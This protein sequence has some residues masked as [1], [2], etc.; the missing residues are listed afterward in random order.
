MSKSEQPVALVTGGT[1]GIG[2]G[3]AR[4]LLDKK[5]AVIVTGR[6][7]EKGERTRTELATHGRVDFLPVDVLRQTQV[8]NMV[9]QVLADHGRL[10]VLVNNAGGSSGFAPVHQLS[11]EAWS[12][13]FNWNVSSAFWA[14]RRALPA[15][16]AA[17]FGRII[18]ISSVQGKQANRPNASHYVMA[19]HAINGFTKAVALEYGKQGITCNALCVGAVETDLMREAGARAAKAAGVSYEE[20]RD[21]YADRAMTGKLNTVEE[22]GA[23]AALLASEQGAGITGAILNIDGGICPY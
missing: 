14:C 8:E 22:V 4:A 23:M 11:D 17:G 18:N 9:D 13:A 5:M 21:R 16:V 20:Y 6:D 7:P 19:K 10:D 1:A 12:Q 15:M 2:R 3:I